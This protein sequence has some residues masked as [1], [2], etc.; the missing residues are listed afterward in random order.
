MKLAQSRLTAQGQIS[1]PVQ[2]RKRLALVAGSILEWDADEDRITVRRAGSHDFGEIHK[3]LFPSE[4][5]AHG[6][7]ELKEGIRKHIRARHAR[8]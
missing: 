4:P 7:G 8:G 2:V 1:V 6:L 5:M 3:V